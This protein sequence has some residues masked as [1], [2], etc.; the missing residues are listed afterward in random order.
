MERSW[1]G[2]RGIQLSSMILGS[3]HV[4]ASPDNCLLN[5]H[6]WMNGQSVLPDLKVKNNHSTSIFILGLFFTWKLHSIGILLFLKIADVSITIRAEL[7]LEHK[8]N[9]KV[10]IEFLWWLQIQLE[11]AVS[12]V[13]TAAVPPFR[14]TSNS[15]TEWKSFIELDLLFYCIK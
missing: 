11:S 7:V 8:R 15:S 3:C 1:C 13:S 14:R 12:N 4:W 5:S 9:G 2:Y 6:Q 10:Q